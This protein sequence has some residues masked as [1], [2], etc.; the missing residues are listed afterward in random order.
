MSKVAVKKSRIHGYGMF[1]AEG[2]QWG[3]K[4]IEYKGEIINDK[5][6]SRRIRRGAKCIMILADNKNIDGDVGGNA[7]RF[8]NHS[9]RNANSFLLRDEGKVYIVAGVEGISKGEEIL[10]DYGKDYWK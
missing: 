2:I 8:A 3:K 5:E 6:A 7:A 9:R 10:F 4:I 1:A